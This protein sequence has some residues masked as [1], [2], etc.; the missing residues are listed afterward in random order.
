MTLSTF[1]RYLDRWD[2][3]PDG[4]PFATPTST[5]LRVWQGESPAM[6][7]VSHD[8]DERHARTLLEWWAGDGAAAV[9]AWEGDAVLMERATGAGSLSQMA[10]SRQDAQACKIICQVAERLHASRPKRVPD[11]MPLSNWFDDL[12][13]A[14][15]NHGGILKRCAET[16]QELLATPRDVRVLHGDLHHDNV[17]DFGMRGWL[18]IDP[19]RLIGERGF[20][21]ANIFTN[22][23]LSDRT[24]PVATDSIRFSQRIDLVASEAKLERKR[25]LA[26][27]LAW[28]GLSATWLLEDEDPLAEV[29]LQVAALAA[30]ELDRP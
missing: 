11:L 1:E 24:Q 20:D 25:L 19:K 29:S 26:W 7:K 6:L 27:V 9:L 23:D 22:P 3:V 2:L 18:A 28:T 15:V 5:L 4:S 17:L 12:R 16:A 13:P 30:T 10:R 8:P 21:Y 14:A